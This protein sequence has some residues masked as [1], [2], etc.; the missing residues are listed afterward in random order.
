MHTTHSSC[1]FKQIL[2]MLL[3]YTRDKSIASAIRMCDF[4]QQ[5]LGQFI[6]TYKV[7]LVDTFPIWNKNP[8][9]FFSPFFGFG[10]ENM[11]IKIFKGLGTSA[12]YRVTWLYKIMDSKLEPIPLYFR[13]LSFNNE[14]SRQGRKAFEKIF[15]IC[16]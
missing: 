11:K 14:K 16:Q 13:K 1:Y 8:I 10:H 4:K 7:F 15:Y 9:Y 5:I 6:F 2:C 3:C 12:N